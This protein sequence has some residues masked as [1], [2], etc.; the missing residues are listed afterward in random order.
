MQE[1]TVT[2]DEARIRL[3]V[4]L[5]RRAGAASRS[6][7]SGWI[8][9][10][11]VFVNGQEIGLAEASHHVA[12]GDC[13]RVWLDRPGS[14]KPTDRAVAGVR[15]H[16]RTVHEDSAIVVVDK[17]VG[18]IVEPLPGEAV[19]EPTMLDLLVDAYRHV[20]R[21]H[22]YVVHRIDRDTSGLVL[23]ARSPAAR[24]HLKGQFERRTPD[25]IYQAVVL[26]A[27]K[28]E[29]AEWRDRLAWDKVALRQRRAHDSDAGA[30]EAE[31]RVRV[32]ERFD[33]AATL[34]EVS[35]VTGKRNQIRVQAGL[36]GHPLLGER[37]Y[38]FGA[39][40]EPAGLPIID[41]QAL[42]AWGLAFVH[43]RSKQHVS[44]T[45][46]LPDDISRLLRALRKHSPRQARLL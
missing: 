7:A 17:P 33:A 42:H 1:W 10:G 35:L 43:P 3:D 11:K 29:S 6:R 27:L 32:L 8:E 20:P 18:M 15:A 37:Q 30:K 22:V 4:W 25:R 2:V 5:V 21:A 28:T 13:V 19:Q 24:D 36:R 39:P 44:F 38:R 14:S 23:F 26:G 41:R 31:A 9:R 34:V 16:L 46:P 12:A 40:P 45:A